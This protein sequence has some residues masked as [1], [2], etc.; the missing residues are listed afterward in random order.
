[1]RDLIG[2]TYDAGTN[3]GEMAASEWRQTDTSLFLRDTGDLAMAGVRGGAVTNVGSAVTIA[4]FTVVV[5]PTAAT[6][7]YRAAFPSG[8][9]ELL[10]TIP[11]AHATLAR[12]DALDVK[13]FDTEADSSGLRGADTVITAGT[14]GSGVAPSF[15]GNGVRLGTFAVP[16]ASGGSPVWTANP[17]LVGYAAAGGILDIANRPAS[18]RAGTVIYNR[19]TGVLEV[20]HAG[21]WRNIMSSVWSSW[22]PIWTGASQNPQRGN[23]VEVGAYRMSGGM[24]D[25]YWKYTYGTSFVVGI[26]IWAW[27]LP[28]VA[29]ADYSIASVGQTIFNDASTGDFLTRSAVIV[30]N[31]GSFAAVTEAGVRLG[32]AGPV[33]AQG[34]TLGILL[35]YRPANEAP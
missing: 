32:P 28:V 15:T 12:V 27:G 6:G 13:V 23:G 17:N 10:K 4:P 1:M 19:A 30:G 9:G 35:R 7:V 24:V 3:Q 34:D 2:I 5:Q 8:A 25:A 16:A 33:P 29:H 31:T 26:G 14:P 18:P 21:A 11:A 20:F 22:V